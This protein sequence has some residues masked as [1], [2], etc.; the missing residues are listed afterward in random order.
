MAKRLMFYNVKTKK[1]VGL[2]KYKIK[3][4]KTKRGI[5]WQAVGDDKGTPVYRF[6]GPGDR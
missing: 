3:K 4:I 2:T 6:V 1:K 5:R